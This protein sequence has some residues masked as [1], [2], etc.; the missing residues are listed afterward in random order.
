MSTEKENSYL[1][2]SIDPYFQGG[3]RL[4]CFIRLFYHLKIIQLEMGT[5]DI[6]LQQ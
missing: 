4:Y 1:D 3:N 2:Y 6:F 5:E